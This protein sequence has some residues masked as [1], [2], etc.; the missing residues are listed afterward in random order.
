MAKISQ[1]TLKDGRSATRVSD[2]QESDNEVIKALI[3]RFGDDVVSVKIED[4]M[5][6]IEKLQNAHDCKV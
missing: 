2:V 3:S 4:R 5:I 6:E 1:Y